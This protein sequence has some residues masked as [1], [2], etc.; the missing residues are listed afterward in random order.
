MTGSDACHLIGKRERRQREREKEGGGILEILENLSKFVKI[1]RDSQLGTS[2][3]NLKKRKK[4][5][6]L[7][8]R[9]SLVI[10]QRAII[11]K[12]IGSQ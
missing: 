12:F 4:N 5:I 2:L 10:I 9:T 11:F 8:P 3:L 6:F 7:R 1:C